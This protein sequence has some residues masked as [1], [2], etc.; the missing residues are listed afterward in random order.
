MSKIE[1]HNCDC[2]EYM[3]TLPD[4]YFKLAICD[5]PYGIG[6]S[7]QKKAICKNSKYN[8]KLHI[9]KMWDLEI[10]PQIYFSELFRISE[11]CI[12][13]GGITLCSICSLLWVGFFGTKGKN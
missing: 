10:P 8:R 1:L 2:I 7:G 9:D 4:N 13:W 6:K 11:N 5:P 12:I 3:K